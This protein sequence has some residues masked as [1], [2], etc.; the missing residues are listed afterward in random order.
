MKEVL[1]LGP[2]IVGNLPLCLQKWDAGVNMAR[3]APKTMPV[4]IMVK[5]IPLELWDT[6]NICRIASCVGVPLTFDKVTRDKC[7]KQNTMGGFARVLVEVGLDCT[8][9]ETIT[10]CYPSEGIIPGKLVELQVEYQHKPTMCS[11]CGVFGH[12]LEKCA[13]RP[14]S[15]EEINMERIE[16]AKRESQQGS[17][18]NNNRGYKNPGEEDEDG[19]TM[20]T[21]RK[22][23]YNT[24]KGGVGTSRGGQGHNGY[25]E[26]GN[27]FRDTRPVFGTNNYKRVNAST[28]ERTNPS[29]YEKEVDVN[30]EMG[31]K[32]GQGDKKHERGNNNKKSAHQKPN[33][34]PKA[35]SSNIKIIETENRYNLLDEDNMVI[36]EEPVIDLTK[37]SN[38]GGHRW[39]NQQ[40][41]LWGKHFADHLSA[42]QK[43]WALDYTTKKKVPSKRVYL[44]WPLYL[45]NY[46]KYLCERG[47]FKDGLSVNE[48]DMYAPVVED[49]PEGIIDPVDRET[50][51]EDL[52]DAEPGMEVNTE[53][54]RDV[55]SET[56]GTARFMTSDTVQTKTQDGDVDMEDEENPSRVHC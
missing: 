41:K 20:V 48:Y 3:V 38:E 19:F 53:D 2:W 7:E 1:E 37:D 21:N 46:F 26:S 24:A 23:R 14:R 43:G 29:V 6:E 39:E 27:R 28:N 36:E 22:A 4:W 55:E 9:Q 11:F 52:G 5:N 56:D 44:G 31:Q 34:V 10:T 42:E 18:G 33:W 12:S 51:E 32:E 25:K 45:R 17:Q 50:E 8:F 35:K 13:K 16:R 49:L 47:T 15:E 54:G 40:Q 30:M